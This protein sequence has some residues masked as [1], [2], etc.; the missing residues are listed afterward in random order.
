MGKK[1]V[2]WM[3][4]GAQAILLTFFFG[5]LFVLNYLD[6]PATRNRIR[7]EHG[8]LL[9]SA[10]AS[11]HKDRGSYPTL[12][13]NP[14]DD[15]KSALV[16]GGYLKAIPREPDPARTQYRYSSSGTIYALLFVQEKEPTLLGEKPGKACLEGVGNVSGLWGLTAAC[17]F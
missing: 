16:D 15:L 14:V 11:F 1:R 2:F 13:D 7:I 9:K 6:V 4:A 8:R 3:I 10:L 12:P 17:E 5:T